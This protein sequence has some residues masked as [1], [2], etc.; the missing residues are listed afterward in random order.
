MLLVQKKRKETSER[1]KHKP[2]RLK[3]LLS[4]PFEVVGC[5]YNTLFNLLYSIYP[6]NDVCKFGQCCFLP[7]FLGN[8][9]LLLYCP[10]EETPGNDF[11]IGLYLNQLQPCA[12]PKKS[13]TLFSVCAVNKPEPYFCFVP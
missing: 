7:S 9:C 3:R 5:I 1:G 12:L 2:Q 6:M 11:S 4:P 13:Q 10:K 8:C